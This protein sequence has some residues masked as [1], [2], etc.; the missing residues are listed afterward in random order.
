MSKSSVGDLSQQ[1]QQKLEELISLAKDQG[2]LTYEEINDVLPMS[3]DS[4]EQIDQIMTTEMMMIEERHTDGRKVFEVLGK[5]APAWGMIGT[6]IGL[7][8]MLG[9]LSN[10]ASIGPNMAVALITTLYGS[11]MANF[12]FLPMADKL[13]RRHKEETV[14]KQIITQGVMAI[15][16]GDNPRIVA[17]KLRIFL[18]PSREEDGARRKEAS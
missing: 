6:L 14:L 18:P 9:N 1:H 13:D 3:F 11:I 8:L 5:Y 15:Q 17:M 12:L 16:V 7:V 10:F 2:Y 4:P